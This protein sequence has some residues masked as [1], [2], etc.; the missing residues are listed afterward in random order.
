MAAG[1]SNFK[2]VTVTCRAP[3][4]VISFDASADWESR[5]AI[6][7]AAM[8]K[9]WGGSQFILVPHMAGKVNAALLRLA[10]IHDPDHVF[11]FNFSDD[12]LAKCAGTYKPPTE[13]LR[14]AV[15][16]M[17]SAHNSRPPEA[18][19][20]ATSV[21]RMEMVERRPPSGS[22]F[23]TSDHMGP[24]TLLSGMPGGNNDGVYQAVPTE[25]GGSIGL[26]MA[27]RAGFV[28]PPTL[29]FVMDAS[30]ALDPRD[31]GYAL[32]RNNPTRKI[33]T[34]TGGLSVANP[35]PSSVPESWRRT[36]PGIDKIYF[37]ADIL[38][39]SITVVGSTVEDFCLA[40]ALDRMTGHVLWL[41]G[42][43]L[44]DEENGEQIEFAIFEFLNGAYQRNSDSAITS[45]SW[46]K[47]ALGQLVEERF[48]RNF[49][50]ATDSVDVKYIAPIGL[51][52]GPPCLLACMPSDFGIHLTLPTIEDNVGGI[53]L[54]Q[55][56]PVHV[57][58]SASLAPKGMPFW[59]VDVTVEATTTPMG[60][61]SPH[62]MIE[63]DPS[64]FGIT[65]AR[66]SQA[67]I[68]FHAQSQGLI[69]AGQP[70]R[71]AIARPKLRFPNLLEWIQARCS[72]NGHFSS[73]QPSDAGRRAM[74]AADLYGGRDQL[75][76][77]LQTHGRLFRQFLPP[78]AKKGMPYPRGPRF[79]HQGSRRW[80]VV[81]PRSDE[82]PSPGHG[83]AGNEGRRPSPARHNAQPVHL[84]SWFGPPLPRLSSSQLLRH[85]CC[86]STQP[87][88]TL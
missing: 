21:Y 44:A 61:N 73:A 47:E 33:L 52:S 45:A 16:R 50:V 87:V 37:T 46:A 77:G 27:M 38:R 28:E 62:K 39:T 88:H 14:P 68:S 49:V 25:C 42:D 5:A 13:E 12:E 4:A 79:L 84:A 30:F 76:E 67:G 15:L 20:E 9:Y 83:Y 19:M 63:G 43:L 36:E 7:I 64:Y 60:R 59:E 66:S 11:E 23:M 78:I 34:S 82:G 72:P 85:R 48:R 80:R 55:S 10:S 35:E 40:F 53:N 17:R 81:V 74:V 24:I 2:D 31:F 69:L 65:T 56:I 86:W 29:P 1:R 54:T 18:L 41:A 26:A 71:H 51:A 3:R 6:V 70:L 8:G 22:V 75:A 58:T 32:G 57:P